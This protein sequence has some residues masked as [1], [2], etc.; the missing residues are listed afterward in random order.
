MLDQG[1]HAWLIVLVYEREP[2]I[3]FCHFDPQLLELVADF[4]KTNEQSPRRRIVRTTRHNM[5]EEFLGAGREVLRCKLE[6]FRKLV[7]NRHCSKKFLYIPRN[8]KIRLGNGHEK[9]EG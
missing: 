8:V 9:V 5:R 4:A 7:K 6:I 3:G 2:G 1:M